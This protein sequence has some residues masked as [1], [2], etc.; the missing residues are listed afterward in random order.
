[1]SKDWI[2]DF[3]NPGPEFRSTV[4]WS[5]NENMDPQQV[6]KQVQILKQGGM[7]GGFIHSRIGL[8][9]E[10]LGSK[11]FDA[12]DA[13]ID[14]SQKLQMLMY[15][16]DEDKWPSGFAAGKVPLKHESFRM[17]AVI[18]RPKGSPKP[19]QCKK[20]TNNHPDLDIYIYTAP[21][22]YDWFNGTSYA[23]LMNNDAMDYFLELS[24]KSY[25]DRYG[26]HYGSLIPAHF[27]DEPC[28]I[29]RGNLLPGA[30]PYSNELP[31]CFKKLNG[32]DPEQKYHLLFTENEQAA[33][34]RLHYF[35]T[36][37]YL[38]E[39]NFSE[40]LG[41]WCKNHKIDLTGHYMSEQSIFDQQLWGT[42][43]MPNYK[44]Q[45]I[46]GIDHLGR[47]INER[48][49]AKQC[50]SVVNQFGK[51]K[52]LSELF[53]CSGQAVTFEDRWWIAAQQICLGVTL[54]NPHLSLYTMAG[55]RKRDF[56]PNIFFQ[57]PWWH[58]N[59]AIE[60]PLAR[61]CSVMSK[62]N[63][64]PQALIIHPQ[65]SAFALWHSR[66]DVD[67]QQILAE[68]YK[69]DS[70]PVY[71]DSVR[72][73]KLLD[74]KFK[75]VIDSLLM[76][77]W[78]FDL[79]DEDILQQ[80]AGINTQNGKT[81]LNVEKQNYPAVIV[82]QMETIR[83][84]TLQLLRSFHQQGGTVILAGPAPKLLDGE[85]S[86]QLDQ[87]FKNFKQTKPESV[88]KLLEKNIEP[89]V[90]I[91]E[92]T[93][94]S[95]DMLWVHT[96]QLE[97]DKRLVY[98]VNLSRTQTLSVNINCDG[99][100]SA[101]ENLD[102]F[103]SAIEPVKAEKNQQSLTI[104]QKFYP[105][106]VKMFLLSQNENDTAQNSESATDI[107]E[108]INLDEIKTITRTD[109]NALTLDR[110]LF[111][112]KKHQ[113]SSQPVD[114]VCIQKLLNEQKYK[115][116]VWL[117]YDFNL[118]KS[119]ESPQ[120]Q[121]VIEHPE[122]YQIKVNDKLIE[123][124][125]EKTWRDPLWSLIDIA[126]NITHGK[127]TIEL[128]CSKFHF[129]DLAVVDDPWARYGTEIE[130]IYLLGDFSVKSEIESAG[131]DLKKWKDPAWQA[132]GLT[133]VPVHRLKADQITLTESEKLTH[134]DMVLQGLPFYPGNIKMEI[135]LPAIPPQCK[136]VTLRADDIASACLQV[137]INGQDAGFLLASF[138]ELDITEHV[139]NGIDKLELIL[140]GT[141]R[142]LLGPHH[143]KDGELIFNS[144]ESFLPHF[145]NQDSFT[146]NFEK[147]QNK[148]ITPSDWHHDYCLVG[149]GDIKGLKLQLY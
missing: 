48:V 11:W 97:P 98:L 12:V 137:I 40:K 32:Y 28:T 118:D 44:H 9:T 24:Y 113:W 10:Y 82:P 107:A 109:K 7:G 16:Y 146:E 133:Y 8:I 59:S 63:Y 45:Q 86:D 112:T 102:M 110:A 83:A 79:G 127:N 108:S 65:E 20:I 39:H 124:T 25:C 26:Q 142:N 68:N 2:N 77:Q 35:R 94:K 84:S 31:E 144:P 125:T 104:H 106:Q 5:W 130:S 67:N 73:I 129:G 135:K 53:G 78:C 80:H 103:T 76:S 21:L 140:Y 19:P 38:F 91:E 92:T 6:R 50:A 46:P 131:N 41:K 70:A 114:L 123:N 95:A 14:E 90:K 60:D 122:Y 49:T 27:T 58:T 93:G 89:H 30:V 56:P 136:K 120:L 138:S 85:K 33:K 74:E 52:M 81:V 1:M 37:N 55:C 145:D 18:A 71:D 69:W 147:W 61:I 134:K 96:R 66:S 13:A 126:E 119:L 17:K 101:A 43:I 117:K 87:F 100:F 121:M 47:Q 99:N 64:L 54:L 62:G 57:Q 51:K 23:D 72:K 139:K 29:F 36:V 149:F 105:S 111:K 42:K 132:Q 15:L 75:T 141:L 128:Y 115:G 3:N 4:F 34:F 116:P 88:A 22:G 148:K 143:H